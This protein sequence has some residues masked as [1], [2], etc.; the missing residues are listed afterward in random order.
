MKRILCLVLSCIFAC[1]LALT[2][3]E[4]VHLKNGSVIKGDIIEETPG[5]SLKIRTSDGNIFV[6]KMDDIELIEKN[7]ASDSENGCNTRHR[8]LDFSLSTGFNVA[9]KGGGGSVPVD[10]TI[11]KRFS[12]YFS[13]GIATGVEIGTSDGAKPIIPI[14]AD[15]RGF[16][17]LRNTKITPF[18][19]LRLGYAVNTADSYTVGS[20]KHKFTVEQPNYVTFS[21][22][23]GVRM[24]LS[25]RVDLDLALGYEHYIST[26]SNGGGTGA[27]AIRA[28]FNFHAST[29]PGYHKEKKPRHVNPVWDS[30]LEFAIEANGID[31]YGGSLLIG[32]KWSPKFSIALGVGVNHRT[33]EINNGVETYYKE[34]D[35]TGD[36]L[37]SS[38][39]WWGDANS[40]FLKLYL[41]GQ[42]RMLD[43]KFSPIA[44]VDLGYTTDT[45]DNSENGSSQFYS[46]REFDL[47][48]NPKGF[49]VRPAIG[50]SMRM[51]SNSYLELRAGYNFTPGVSSLDIYQNKKGTL[52]NYRREYNSLSLV[53]E[54]KSLSHLFVALSYK[55]TFSLFSRH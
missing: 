36:V 39:M 16:L 52:G 23:P 29:D 2:A 26:G 43:R 15:F 5:T 25:H 53:R 41:R 37:Y 28:G 30:G 17:P 46:W 8:K 35:C 51:G 22:M 44:S 54:G 48:E 13:A 38:T 6:Y 9:T 4:T 31:E 50:V 49:F 27:F 7:T 10:V 3:K 11:S 21:I 34:A 12:P 20:G 18:A 40:N 32:Y 45:Y 33:Y 42:Y 14:L 55:H 1:G 19:N 24:P 47:K